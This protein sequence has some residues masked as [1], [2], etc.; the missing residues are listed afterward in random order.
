VPEDWDSEL[1]G[2]SLD[3]FAIDPS[4]VD[5][6]HGLQPSH[7]VASVHPCWNGF[8]FFDVS[9]VSFHQVAEVTSKKKRMSIVGWFHGEPVSRPPFMYAP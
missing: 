4:T 7:T 2:G 3:L 6:P 8:A 9:T 5:S 1:D